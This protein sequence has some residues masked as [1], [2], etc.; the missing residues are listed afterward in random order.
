MKKLSHLALSISILGVLFVVWGCNKA[1]G[2]AAP[3]TSNTGGASSTEPKSAEGKA[4]EKI[5]A[6]S[7]P[8]LASLPA[9]LKHEGYAYSGLE[10]DKT[11]E[12][13]IKR[14]T[15]KA[16]QV[17]TQTNK[18]VSIEKGVAKFTTERTGLLADLVGTEEVELRHDG[19]YTTKTG[20]GPANPAQLDLPSE[21]PVGKTWTSHGVVTMLDG[22]TIE[23]NVSFK[24]VGMEK[25]KTKAGTYDSL[26]VTGS[27]SLKAAGKE[28]KMNLTAWYVKGLGNVLLNVSSPE[29]STRQEA[30]K[31]P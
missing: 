22:R 14:P 31:I 16:P 28:L 10:C 5:S 15:D 3:K 30:T 9:D 2:Q 6:P 8:P 20:G 21:M 24:V 13:E 7:G 18:L 1:P 25:V 4:P 27:G 26:K 23:Q 19:I 17:G 11:M 29:G 12:F